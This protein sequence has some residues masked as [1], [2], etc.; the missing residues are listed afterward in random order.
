MNLY[1]YPVLKRVG[2]QM[3]FLRFFSSWMKE[4]AMGKILSICVNAQSKVQVP[5]IDIFLVLI[6]SSWLFL[7]TPADHG[8]ARCVNNVRWSRKRPMCIF[9]I[10]VFRYLKMPSCLSKTKYIIKGQSYT[11]VLIY[12]YANGN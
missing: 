8:N 4:F 11:T 9:W 5:V 6:K 12:L 10:G 1:L 7:T 2:S 3:P